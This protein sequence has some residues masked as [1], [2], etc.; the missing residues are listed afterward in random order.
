VSRMVLESGLLPHTNAGVL[1]F[2]ELKIL[3]DVNASLGL[4]L[5]TVSERLCGVGM[6]HFMSPD[7]A[8]AARLR[9]L[10]DAGKLQI[11]I[12]TGILIGIGETL[13]ERV[14]S[15]VAL[16]EI[17]R[18]Y[19][20]IQEVIVQ[21]FRAKPGTPMADCPEPGSLEMVTTVAVARLLLG[22]EMNVQAPPNLFPD[23]HRLLLKAGIN[24]WGGISPL[25]A[26]YVN[27]DNPWP[28]IG[29]LMQMCAEEGFCLRERL[30][31]YPEFVERHGF[32]APSLKTAVA[33][34][35]SV[36]PYS[37]SLQVNPL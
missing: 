27:P 25:T 1:S 6:P 5:E 31:V 37:T 4:M 13:K 34:L 17:H 29:S 21:N 11:P 33:R 14:E 20:H 8:P 23:D 2:E 3:K 28:Q 18:E 16:R 9:M 22:G 12:T 19:G 36:E 10:R 7:K 30:A 15:L 24:D 35:A 26:D 32:L